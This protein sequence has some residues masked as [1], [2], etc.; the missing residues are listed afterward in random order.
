MSA[1]LERQTSWRLAF[2]AIAPG[3]MWLLP[4]RPSLGQVEEASAPSPAPVAAPPLAIDDLAAPQ[5][6]YRQAATRRV[7][8]QPDAYA[9]AVQKAAEGSDR[10]MADRARWIL[11]QWQL[12]LTPE[13]PRDQ[14]SEVR[15]AMGDRPNVTEL[16]NLQQF[17][18]I[19]Q[20]LQSGRMEY[21]M[22]AAMLKDH[23]ERYGVPL[24]DAVQQQS[25]ERLFL[26]FPRHPDML[27]FAVQL[28][29]ASGI[30]PADAIEV[31]DYV[32]QW[33][34]ALRHRLDAS[35]LWLIDRREEAIELARKEG[36]N[37]LLES[38]LLHDLRWKELLAFAEAHPVANELQQQVRIAALAFRADEPSKLAE[39]ISWLEQN[40]SKEPDEKDED[41]SRGRS[42]E[43]PEELL[44]NLLIGLDRV[45]RGIDL[46]R[47]SKSM[48]RVCEVRSRQTRVREAFQALGIEVVE[49]DL[50]KVVN[51]AV[52]AAAE[53]RE[54]SVRRFEEAKEACRIAYLYGHRVLAWRGF[55]RLAETDMQN[56]IGPHSVL[57]E[58]V[59][60]RQNRND[61]AIRLIQVNSDL[62]SRELAEIAQ[63]LQQRYGDEPFDL[64]DQAITAIVSMI[65]TI[66]PT[67]NAPDQSRMW[68]LRTLATL[69]EPHWPKPLQSRQ[70]QADFAEGIFDYLRSRQSTDNETTTS[71]AM[72]LQ[73]LGRP[74]LAL[75]FLNETTMEE[76]SRVAARDHRWKEV[77]S[78]IEAMPKSSQYLSNSLSLWALALKKT[79]RLDEGNRWTRWFTHGPTTADRLNWQAY[80][81]SR[82]GSDQCLIDYGEQM[83]KLRALQDPSDTNGPLFRYV[84][85][86]LAEAHTK[87][88][89]GRTADLRD[90]Y[91]AASTLGDSLPAMDPEYTIATRFSIHSN[92]GLDAVR[93]GDEA[94]ARKEL[95][96]ACDLI[97]G[98]V[99]FGEDTIKELDENGMSQVGDELF[100]RIFA[101]LMT[102]LDQYPLD[103]SSWNNAAWLAAKAKRRTE[104]ALPLVQRAILLEP[105]SS[106]Y[107]DTLADVLFITGQREQ[108]ITVEQ[109]TIFD[110]PDMWHLH[111][112]VQRFQTP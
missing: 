105:D 77:L 19:H 60:I 30:E 47:E 74:D 72:W 110:E 23:C 5:F 57:Q 54:S 15:K 83:L 56:T 92:R 58:L 81:F 89:P 14:A 107:R 1:R 100:D 50:M 20:L 43:D 82:Y 88:I 79:G 104:Q 51:E 53:R 97:P 38:M 93:R 55:Q 49:V 68:R 52:Q 75:P 18:S 3:L 111:Q 42:E 24:L 66:S 48:M 4:I 102:H 27:I 37:P 76:R 29:L 25:L 13:T 21:D 45:D 71:I 31:P 65:G 41:Q 34:P 67:F 69:L 91:L 106:S 17:D 32:A 6:D 59:R 70:Q 63:Q 35:L 33:E 103:A 78:S 40:A 16:F 98:D 61:W 95:L 12:G 99:S 28:R 8:A 36:V 9:E 90:L 39:A 7:W 62:R 109:H 96:A 112:Q 11:E 2:F 26:S 64:S 44:P 87:Q 108:A 86:Q 85:F 22:T 80:T 10:E 73:A 101:H 94:T 84:C 46:L